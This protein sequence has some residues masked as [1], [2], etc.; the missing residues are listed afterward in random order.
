MNELR[1]KL[2]INSSRGL[3]LNVILESEKDHAAAVSYIYEL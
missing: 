1:N 3:I 2:G